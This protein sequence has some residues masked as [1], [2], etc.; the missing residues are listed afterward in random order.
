[1]NAT[2]KYRHVGRCSVPFIK[3][4]QIKTHE[5]GRIY[6]Q[7]TVF[8]LQLNPVCFVHKNDWI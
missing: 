8:T 5:R 1:M 3:K 6:T 4:R 7:T 2:I